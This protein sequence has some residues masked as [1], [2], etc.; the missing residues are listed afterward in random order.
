MQVLRIARVAERELQ[1]V[2]LDEL[3]HAPGEAVAERHV[4]GRIVGDGDLPDLQ[5]V[6]DQPFHHENLAL[7]RHRRAPLL[8]VLVD[9]AQTRV[10]RRA[11][12]LRVDEQPLAQRQPAAPERRSRDEEVAEHRVARVRDEHARIEPRIHLAQEGRD[13]RVDARIERL[14]LF[15][16]V[17]EAGA[18]AGVRRERDHVGGARRAQELAHLHAAQVRLGVEA[19]REEPVERALVEHRAAQ[20][21]ADRPVLEPVRPFASRVVERLEVGV[22]HLARVGVVANLVQACVRCHDAF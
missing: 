12:R 4:E 3:R 21:A 17:E 19:R 1:A 18:V 8:A 10:Q 7:H 6:R 15:E 13:R 22:D 20:E 16:D 9:D 2:E 11:R 14:A 5:Q